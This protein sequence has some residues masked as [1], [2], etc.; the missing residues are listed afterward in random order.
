MPYR[1][2]FFRLF[3]GWN[4]NILQLMPFLL[5]QLLFFQPYCLFWLLPELFEAQFFQAHPFFL[6]FLLL[7]ELGFFNAPALSFKTP[8]AFF[9]ILPYAKFFL[10][11][12]EC[13]WRRKLR[14]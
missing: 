4:L 14:A 9:Q 1:R 10:A 8:N 5:Q 11:M 12:R 13:R 7:P 3:L 2:L 6:C